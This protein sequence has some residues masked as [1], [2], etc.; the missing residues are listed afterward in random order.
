M[1]RGILNLTG[2]LTASGLKS[3]LLGMA[4]LSVSLCFAMPVCAS[5]PADQQAIVDKARITFRAFMS[6]EKMTWFHDHLKTARGLII[7][8]QML[9]AGFFLG[10][11]GGTGVLVVQDRRT[12]D[13]SQPVFYTIGSVSFGLQFGGEAA[14]IIVMV[15]KDRALDSLYSTS[16]NLGGDFSIALGP[17]GTG[18]KSNVIA[19]FISFARSKGLY[20]GISLEGAVIDVRDGYNHTYY[21]R[22]VRPVDIIVK[23]TVANR[24]SNALRA[25]LKKAVK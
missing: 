2:Y 6:D 11:S 17:V 1:L 5:D 10:G 18:L 20:A 12:G 14:E 8:P 13:W 25:A 23:R 22:D 7:I 15:M 4:F 21:Q 19:D 9:K 24:G 3:I 16:V